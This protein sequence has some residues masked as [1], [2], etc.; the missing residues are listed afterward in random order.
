MADFL[1]GA[2]GETLT[3]DIDVQM[4]RMEANI[5][6]QGYSDGFLVGKEKG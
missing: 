3:R 4:D 2:S 6:K 1:E 5:H